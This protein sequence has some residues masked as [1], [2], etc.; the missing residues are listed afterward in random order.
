MK[1]VSIKDLIEFRQ[2]SVRSKK[3]FVSNL[4]KNE[5]HSDKVSGRDYWSSGVG[6][7]SSSFKKNSLQPIFDRKEELIIKYDSATHG[8][9]KLMFRRNIEILDTYAQMNNEKWK[10]HNNVAFDAV[11]RSNFIMNVEGVEI[12][13]RPSVVF[14]YKLDDIKHVGGVWFVSQKNG[15]EKNELGMFCEALFRYLLINYS[16]E[17]EIN[18]S[19]CTAVDVCKGSCMNYSD[20][21]KNTSLSLLSS[22]IN[23][24]KSI[25]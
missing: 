6:A 11:S 16:E 2:K 9:S 14:T 22:T 7:I 8:N 13:M 12:K 21:M 15:F 5:I 17:Y 25:S 24:I 1:V 10:P 23:E 3:T 18:S 19:Y 4:K 20:L